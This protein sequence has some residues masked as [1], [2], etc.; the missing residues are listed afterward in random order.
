MKNQFLG[1]LNIADKNASKNCMEIN[2]KIERRSELI[3]FVFTK[4]SV[5]GVILPALLLTTVNY[6]IYGLDK[7][8]YYLPFPLM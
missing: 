2:E 8:S 3:Y 6:F 5:P 7:E 4:L 1:S